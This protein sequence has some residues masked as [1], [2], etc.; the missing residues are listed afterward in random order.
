MSLFVSILAYAMP[1]DLLLLITRQELNRQDFARQL[2]EER[3]VLNC[4]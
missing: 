1:N 3:K 2:I 4:A